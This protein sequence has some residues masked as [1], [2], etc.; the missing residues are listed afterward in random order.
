MSEINKKEVGQ[1]LKY[2]RN[3][4][5]GM[6]QRKFGETIGLKQ[7]SINEIESGN[8]S[9]TERNLNLICNTHNANP[10]WLLYGIEPIFN[11][12]KEPLI[13]IIAKE[14]SL[15]DTAKAVVD[16]YLNLTGEEQ[17]LL[18]K[19]ILKT[20]SNSNIAKAKLAEMLEQEKTEKK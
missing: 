8:N 16:T 17:Q 10:K 4:Y 14:Y 3:E 20:V 6:S 15:S 1:R 7:S 13:D 2:F 18:E 19:F 9:L 5:L 12:P 11:K